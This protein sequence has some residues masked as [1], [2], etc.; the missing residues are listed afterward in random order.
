MKQKFWLGLDDGSVNNIFAEPYIDSIKALKDVSTVRVP[1]EK[2]NCLVRAI[3]FVCTAVSV[4]SKTLGKSSS[5]IDCAIGSEDLVLL[6]QYIIIRAS[7]PFFFSEL[8]FIS[9]FIPENYIMGEEGYVLATF[10]SALE[11]IENQS[12]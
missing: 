1:V 12:S 6:C 10:Q 8:S 5:D 9:E 3:E 7:V 2:L 11:S 4:F